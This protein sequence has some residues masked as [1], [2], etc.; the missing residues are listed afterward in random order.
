MG[1]LWFVCNE[2]MKKSEELN[3]ELNDDEM[4]NNCLLEVRENE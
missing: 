2:C 3:R 4:C 1:K